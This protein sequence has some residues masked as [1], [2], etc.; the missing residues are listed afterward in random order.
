M[1]QLILITLFWLTPV[2]F[3]WAHAADGFGKLTV[4]EVKAKLS[5]KNVY[6]FDNNAP[7]VFK[8]AHLPAAKWLNPSDYDPKALP[9]DK[10][11]TLIF[12]CHNEH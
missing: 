8:D 9:S 10:T 1:R 11:A 12:Y 7:E 2:T 4:Q 5:Q 6:L 3:Q